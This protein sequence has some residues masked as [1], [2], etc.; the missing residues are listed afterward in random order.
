[1]S[2]RSIVLYTGQ[3]GYDRF[4]DMLDKANLVSII[5][6]IYKEDGLPEAEKDRLVQMVNSDDPGDLLIAKLFLNSQHGYTFSTP[7]T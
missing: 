2:S 7:G 5:D 6:Y 3:E 1:M 4:T